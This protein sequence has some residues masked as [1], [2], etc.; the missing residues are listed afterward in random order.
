MH[1]AVKRIWDLT[2]RALQDSIAMTVD[3]IAGRTPPIPPQVPSGVKAALFIGPTN[4]AGQATRW[5][6]ALEENPLV[7]ARSMV[8][9]ETNSFGYPADYSV[10]WR[11]MTH[12]RSWQ[13]NLLTTLASQYTHVIFEAEMPVL[14]GM[15]G[16]SIRRQVG[17]LQEAGLVVGMVAHGTDVRLPSRHRSLEPWSYFANDD[18]VPVDLLEKEIA[19]NLE[20]LHEI[21][22]PTFVS[23]AGLLIDV[24]DAH[25]LP[26][27]I[28]PGR[29]AN[30]GDVLGRERLR[31]VHAPSNPLPKGTHLIEPVLHRLEQEGLIDYVRLENLTNS[32]MPAMF[33]S[34]D[35][36]LD[37]FRVGDYGVAACEAMAGGRLVVSHVSEQVRA[38]VLDSTGHELPIVEATIDSLEQT[39]RGIHEDRPRYRKIAAQGPGFVEDVHDGR[40]SRSVLE[41]HFLF[42]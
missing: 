20:L 1:S 30:D 34:A 42:S 5:S 21:G 17:A 3:G 14:G 38:A 19:G 32:E 11:T 22:V 2:P 28:E 6:R 35:I 7:A 9:A 33:A 31:I 18:W 12:S 37:Q 24:P 8:C 25:L 26:V 23:T 39:L 16:G 13:R 40:L 15:F 36:L 4:Y 27:V 29:W 41:R 10:R